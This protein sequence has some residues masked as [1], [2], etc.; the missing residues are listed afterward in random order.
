[1]KTFKKI[2]I[3]IAI[4]FAVVFTNGCYYVFFG[5]EKS[6]AKL[7]AGKDLNLY[8]CCSIYTMHMALWM[9]GWPMSKVAAY[10][11]LTLHFPHKQ[12]TTHIMNL[13]FRESLLTPK[14]TAAI[15]T[16]KD[17]PI[18]SSIKV[19]WNGNKDYSILSEERVA[20]IALNPCH[21]EKSAYMQD[22]SALF[23]ITSSMRYP[24]HSES[25]FTIGK[26][27]TITLYEELFRHLQ[28][29]GWLSYYTAAYGIY[30]KWI[31]E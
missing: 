31:E 21:I 10:E 17:S 12:D 16:I 27:L 30:E 4:V 15:K 1:M 29:R 2:L 6:V 5:Q 23:I 28:D 19:S 14:I 8:E 24:E 11:C 20:A 22:G 26:K 18:G 3:S 25:K 13:S 9:F 7:K